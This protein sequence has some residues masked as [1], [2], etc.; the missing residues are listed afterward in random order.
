ML[1]LLN[2]AKNEPKRSWEEVKKSLKKNSIAL[3]SKIDIKPTLKKTSTP[4]DPIDFLIQDVYKEFDRLKNKD[5]DQ[6]ELSEKV[7]KIFQIMRN[8]LL[9][10]EELFRKTGLGAKDF[11]DGLERLKFWLRKF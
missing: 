4:V 8:D 7:Q 10:G 11:D 1:L 9:E 5:L 2:P 6:S 3:P